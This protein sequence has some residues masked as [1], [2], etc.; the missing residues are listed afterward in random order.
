MS[1]NRAA[2]RKAKRMKKFH[3]EL[4]LYPNQVTWITVQ[5]RS[6][7]TAVGKLEDSAISQLIISYKP[8]DSV[9]LEV[10]SKIFIK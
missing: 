3:F 6:Y 5:A 9:P 7:K 8:I 4:R 10:P 1:G 2:I